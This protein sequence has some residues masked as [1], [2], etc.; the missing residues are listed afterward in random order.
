MLVFAPLQ[1]TLQ[2]LEQT[3]IA[4]DAALA[5]VFEI[6]IALATFQILALAAHHL[7]LAA[8]QVLAAFQLLLLATITSVCS[9]LVLATL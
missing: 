6:T 2:T 5:E 7:A 9:R 3:H 1:L 4:V 8:F